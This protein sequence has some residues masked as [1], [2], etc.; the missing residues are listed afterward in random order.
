ML[1]SRRPVFVCGV[2]DMK[3]SYFSNLAQVS[4]SAVFAV[5][6]LSCGG[7]GS[8][9]N[10]SATGN[11]TTNTTSTTTYELVW[12]DEFDSTTPAVPTA[13]SPKSWNMET[14][15]G[16]NGWGNNE[17]QNYTNSLS[18]VYVQNG[19]LVI[20]A[21]CPSGVC[22]SRDGTITS[23]RLNTKNKVT[24]KYGKVQARIKVPSGQGMWPAFWM[25]GGNIDNDGWPKSGEID[26]MEMHFNSSNTYTTHAAAHWFDDNLA[27][28][29]HTY[30]TSSKVYPVP[31]TNDYHIFE[32][33]WDDARILGKIDGI[34]Y[35]I[36]PIDPVSMSEFLNEFYILLNVAVGGNLG[37][38]PITT[39]WPQNMHVDY[40]RVYQKAAVSK[41]G[42]YSET[43]DAA[44]QNYIRI[45]NSDEW[46]GNSVV[47][48]AASTAVAPVDG[49]KVLAANYTL[50]PLAGGASKGW[51]G[52]VFQ[53]KR[54]D[55]SNYNQLVFSLDA[56][57]MA[58]FSDVEVKVEDTRGG[59]F[60]K[61]VRLAAYA[62]VVSGNWK[63]YAIPLADLAGVDFTD[64]FYLGFYGPVNATANLLAG[65]LYFDNIHLNK[66]VCTA[67]GSV[68]L[69]AAAY[70]ANST[71][72]N[73]TVS[74]LCNA[75]KPAVALIDNGSN[76]LGLGMVLDSAGTGA[77]TVNFGV[78]DLAT[79]TL[80]VVSGDTLTVNYT[81]S[82]SATSTASAAITA[83]TTGLIGDINNDGYVYVYAN[84]QAIQD[85]VW[86]AQ[87]AGDYLIDPWGSGATITD[88]FVDTDFGRVL[89]IA[90]G[91]GWGAAPL[92]SVVTFMSMTPGITANYTSL[93]FK[94]KNLP[95]GSIDIMLSSAGVP[96]LRLTHSLAT[97]GTAI[98]G[99]TGWFDV[100]I[101]L[102]LYPDRASYFDIAF[103]VPGGSFLLTDVNFQ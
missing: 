26:I 41:K 91:A 25:L 33:E 102:N 37:G 51:N 64:A 48:N 88:P 31:I 86:G 52:M 92:H 53:L 35:Y 60:A 83:A 49:T 13:P 73:V 74:D 79:N 16:T 55:W 54:D 67:A 5:S 3:K 89:S 62:P 43:T 71:F 10:S 45:I 101:P 81:D 94:V 4:L 39:T 59:A 77:A 93:N 72:A 99:T 61:S 97:V 82:A 63:T 12:S 65:T 14:G 47:A 29:A 20:S 84:N 85:L 95:A 80:A 76:T 70:P 17:M 44:T 6:L 87:P 7:G 30:T 90:P 19:E 23:A 100:S 1:Y 68:A 9:S 40:V 24:A 58:G 11:N 50:A 36:Q 2:I 27:V 18:N 34:I 42:I 57:G 21:Q 8:S 32:V 69:N 56:S 78:T 66:A 38:T 96:E 22:G 103:I 98:P 28:P 75:N 15:Y 46:G